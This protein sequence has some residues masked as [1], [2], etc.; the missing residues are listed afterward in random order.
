MHV[1]AQH[2]WQDLILNYLLVCVHRYRYN[3]FSVLP[4][5]PPYVQVSVGA[6][7]SLT[8]HLDFPPPYDPPHTVML[9]DMLSSLYTALWLIWLNVILT[10]EC[11][12][13]AFPAQHIAGL[14]LCSHLRREHR[15]CR[16][17][18]NDQHFAATPPHM[19]QRT[20]LRLLIRHPRAI[21]RIVSL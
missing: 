15:P 21:Q 5:P 1:A 12:S 2:C 18:V 9:T 20:P 4:L 17:R 14:V 16:Y 13:Q 6:M 7:S 10:S 11:I 19:I 3:H 8:A